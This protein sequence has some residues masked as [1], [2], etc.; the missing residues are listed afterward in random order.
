MA[1]KQYKEKLS[2]EAQAVVD[3]ADFNDPEVLELLGHIEAE[4]VV[5]DAETG[6]V[7]TDEQ[8]RLY[9]A[10]IK[11]FNE[12]GL[13]PFLDDVLMEIEREFWGSIRASIKAATGKHEPSVG[14]R[15]G[16][17]IVVL[18]DVAAEWAA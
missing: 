8:K 18:K 16:W 12:E 11:R 7:M 10:R 14:V 1:M 13:P 6:L 9:A 2:K 4:D 3:G 5:R 15:A 17:K